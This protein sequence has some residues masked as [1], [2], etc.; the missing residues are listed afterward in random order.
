[1]DVMITLQ[2]AGIL[3]APGIA[4]ALLEPRT[5]DGRYVTAKVYET[6]KE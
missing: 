3:S 2:I 5:T 6:A 1:M 4:P